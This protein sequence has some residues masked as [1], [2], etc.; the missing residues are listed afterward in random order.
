MSKALAIL[1]LVI[2]ALYFCHTILTK[3][4]PKQAEY[5]EFGDYFLNQ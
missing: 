5:E 2:L 3:Q 4:P 1:A